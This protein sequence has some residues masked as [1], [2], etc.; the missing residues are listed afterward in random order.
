MSLVVSWLVALALVGWIVQ[1]FGRHH[2]EP[3]VEGGVE[4]D[5]DGAAAG[6]RDA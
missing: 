1:G 4:G 3:G 6:G 5:G 2:P